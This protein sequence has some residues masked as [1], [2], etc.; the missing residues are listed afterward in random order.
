MILFFDDHEI[1]LQGQRVDS[2]HAPDEKEGHGALKIAE[3]LSGFATC[4]DFNRKVTAIPN[5]ALS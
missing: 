4:H 1:P 3:N 2:S 5:F